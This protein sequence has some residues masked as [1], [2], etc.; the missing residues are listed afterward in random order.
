MTVALIQMNSVD[1]PADNLTVIEAQLKLAA[2]QGAQL[3]VLPEMCLSMN[4]RRYQQLAREPDLWRFRFQHWC[5]EYG[6]WL[7]AGAIPVVSP[8][9]VSPEQVV[10]NSHS[11]R[12]VRDGL[13]DGRLRSASLVFDETG[14]QVARYDKIHLFDVDV[15]D[16]QGSYRESERFAPGSDVVVVDTP[17]GALG[18][19]ICYDLRFPELFRA[20]VDAGAELISLPAAFTYSTGQAHWELLIRARAIET[21]CFMLA[22]NQCGWHDAKRQTWGHSML[23]DPWGRKLVELEHQPGVTLATLDL[24]ELRSVRAKMPV[25]QHHRM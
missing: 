20:L 23:V 12:P 25:S 21:Q 19:S 22:A 24:A 4:G 10:A 14:E 16:A 11:D 15:G 1:E 13:Y 2:E 7:V 5:R 3:A 9:Q 6:L 17:V 18:L 8:E